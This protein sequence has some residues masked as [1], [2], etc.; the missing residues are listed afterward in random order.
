[1]TAPLGCRALIGRE[2][3][4]LGRRPVLSTGARALHSM[5]LVDDN[6]LKSPD[7][8]ATVANLRRRFDAVSWGKPAWLRALSGG[9]WARRSRERTRLRALR[10]SPPRLCRGARFAVARLLPNQA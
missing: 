2:T 4:A 7:I 10:G 9:L 6:T 1:M 8:E 3:P 5:L